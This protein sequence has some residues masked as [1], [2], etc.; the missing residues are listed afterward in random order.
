MNAQMLFDAGQIVGMVMRHTPEEW[1]DL[2][3]EARH[4]AEQT[5][6]PFRYSSHIEAIA[7]LRHELNTQRKKDQWGDP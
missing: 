5:P 7:H 2:V 3:I 6:E 1:D 4:D